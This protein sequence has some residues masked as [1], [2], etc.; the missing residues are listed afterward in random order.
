MEESYIKLFR[1]LQ[2]WEWYKNSQM[3]HLFIHLLISANFKDGRFQGIDVKRG[4]L[5]TGR[6]AI[7][8]SIGISEVS[9]RTCLDKL[10]LTNEITIKPTN[11]F[12]LIT[13]VKYNDYQNFE[14]KKTNKSTN[15]STND[16]PTKHQQVATIEEGN[17]DKNENI[18]RAFA[19]LEIT[20][21]DNQKLIDKGYNQNQN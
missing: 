2:D 21:T 8:E 18:Y 9:I 14:T 6:K 5:V 10:K 13:I 20:N 4:Q 3:V 15:K 1:K 7:S 16:Q 11:K 12:S 19:H 17:N